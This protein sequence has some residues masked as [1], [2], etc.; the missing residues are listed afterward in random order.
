MKTISLITC[1]C[2]LL[3][4]S[5]VAQTTNDTWVD[6]SPHTER[7][8]KV[9]GVSLEYL[10]WGGHGEA[11]VFLAGLGNTAHI[12]DNLAPQF[13]NHFHVLGLTRRGYGQSD[14]PPTG[15]DINTLMEDIHQFLDGLGIKR[16]I[17]VG[18]SFAGIELTRFAELYPDGVDKLVYLECAYSFDQPGT[19]EVFSRMESLTPQASPET[20]ANFSALLLQGTTKLSST[21][22]E[23]H[24]RL[25][26]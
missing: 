6:R 18:H 13:T 20:R 11:L 15:Y 4:L 14:K 23:T 10:D 24:S 7:F 9:N 1:Q 17:L 21:S 2:V 26:L 8:V 22:A 3:A 5:T 16:V 12:F 19:V 25:W